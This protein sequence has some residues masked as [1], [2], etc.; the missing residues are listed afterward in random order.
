MDKND[1]NILP[2]S[3]L[4]CFQKLLDHCLAV[5]QERSQPGESPAFFSL[6]FHMLFHKPES[7]VM[8]ALTTNCSIVCVIITVFV[9]LVQ[10]PSTL[11]IWTL[12]HYMK[13][14]WQKL[15][16]LAKRKDRVK[17]LTFLC[18]KVQFLF[19]QTTK[20]SPDTG[21]YNRSLTVLN[22]LLYNTS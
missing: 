10:L 17:Q 16:S 14:Y 21:R 12:Q 9:F 11:C 1:G 4:N 19:G 3:C 22:P 6:L 8:L 13:L 2:I 15:I 20:H 7:D 18:P 5:I